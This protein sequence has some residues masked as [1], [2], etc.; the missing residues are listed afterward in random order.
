[1]FSNIKVD[2]IKKVFLIISLIKIATQCDFNLGHHKIDFYTL[3]RHIEMHLI[4]R[5]IIDS[6]IKIL[7]T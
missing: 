5:S 4:L 2:H 1:M 3:I 7:K 6:N